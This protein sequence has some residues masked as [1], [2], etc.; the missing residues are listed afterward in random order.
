M[1][2]PA[3]PRVVLGI[4]DA[5]DDP[6]VEDP[7]IGGFIGLGACLRKY[8]PNAD[9]RQLVV[10]LSVPCRDYAAVLVGA[11]W[12]LAAES[13]ELEEPIG[14]L[15]N[16]PT[17]SCVRVLTDT[18]VV[19]GTLALF[20]PD[21][22]PPRATVA[23]RMLALDRFR[24]AVQLPGLC[25]NVE[26]EIPESGFLARLAGATATWNERI[27]NP[28][29]DLALVGVRKWL[30]EDLAAL[31]GNKAADHS[32]A[33]PL[34][35]YVL[36][37]ANGVATWATPI[38]PPERLGEGGELSDRCSLAV[39]DGYGAIKYLEEMLVPILVCIVDRSV[40]DAAAAEIVVQQRGAGTT[41]TSLADELHWATPK[42]VEA[43]AFWVAL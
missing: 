39:L 17:G 13:P 36:P 43:L 29:C 27:M 1:G 42:G 34:R 2:S 37:V 14:V 16:T 26:E 15:S 22:S 35:N 40:I 7:F 4:S 20:K 31:V 38:V 30:M 5:I 8:L 32:A 23:G 10:A 28:P 12:M 21:A 6:L 25:S 24:A 18:K 11:G 3:T 9:D 19:A 33:V 41:P